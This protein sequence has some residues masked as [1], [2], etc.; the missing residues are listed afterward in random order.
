MVTLSTAQVWE[1]K[2]T[3]KPKL[4]KSDGCYWDIPRQLMQ[5]LFIHS[6]IFFFHTWS[7]LGFLKRLHC[8]TNNYIT[9]LI[10][11]ILIELTSFPLQPVHTCP[12]PV[13]YHSSWSRFE[14]FSP[15][16]ELDVEQLLHQ[17]NSQP[18]HIQHLGE[19]IFGV[20]G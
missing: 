2:W 3:Y 8:L 15:V 13:P 16:P 6:F 14:S 10:K 20:G 7:F 18:F 4:M 5:Y 11:L 9:I 19:Y 17:R 1:T 12:R